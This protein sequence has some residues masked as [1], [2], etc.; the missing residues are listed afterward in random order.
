MVKVDA[1]VIRR[2]AH[3]GSWYEADPQALHK[4]VSDLLS[5]EDEAGSGPTNRL[6]AVISPHAGIQYSGRVAASVYARVEPNAIKRV[7]MLGPSH[8]FGIRGCALPAARVSS[9]STPLGDLPVDSETL[10]LLRSTG[11]FSDLSMHMDEAE[12]SLEMQLPF[13][14]E[15][16]LRAPGREGLPPLTLVPIIVGQVSEDQERRYGEMLAPFLKTPSDLF[17]I[18]SDF[19]HWGSSFGYQVKGAPEL[20][21]QYRDAPRIENKWIEGLDR[22]GMNL[23]TIQD[24]A[25]FRRYLQRTGNTICGRHPISILLEAL[26]VSSTRVKIDFTRYAQSSMMPGNPPPSV[27]SVSYAGAI[28]TLVD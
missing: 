7:F 2:A 11:E 1:P 8:H 5:V 23:I 9:Y 21:V 16:F 17:V 19:S 14:A 28:C 4:T 24:R 12:H 10:A 6:K 25:G 13:L 27:S 22:E 26:N 15:L 3:S 20:A 18:S